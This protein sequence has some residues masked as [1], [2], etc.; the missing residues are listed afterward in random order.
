MPHGGTDDDDCKRMSV[1]KRVPIEQRTIRFLGW[2]ERVF[3]AII[4]LLLFA[5]ATALLI[6]ATAH[7]AP[8][9]AAGD[10]INETTSFLDLV[11]ATLMVVELAYTVILS[12]RGAVLIAEPFLIVALIAVIRRILVITAGHAGSGEGPVV[13]STQSL[14]E[15]GVLTLVVIAFVASIMALRSR[16]RDPSLDIFVQDE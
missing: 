15:L 6:H 1:P 2:T 12:L 3:F 7:L 4:A 16:P 11:L 9:F 8:M 10:I 5:G 14:L 13:A